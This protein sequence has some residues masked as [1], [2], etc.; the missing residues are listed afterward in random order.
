MSLSYR[1]GRGGLALAGLACGPTLLAVSAPVLGA[2]YFVQPV[3]TVTAEQN[4]NIDLDPFNPSRVAGYGADAAALIGVATPDSETT[5]KPR[6]RYADYPKEST[7][8]RVEGMVDFSTRLSAPRSLF[9][10]SGRFDHLNDTE[11]EAPS[12]QF[13]EVNPNAPTTSDAGR[14]QFG[15]TRNYV[16]LQPRYQYQVAPLVTLGASALFQNESFSVSNP[17]DTIGHVNFNYYLGDFFVSRKFGEKTELLIG[18]FASRYAADNVSP[19]KSNASASGANV[20]LEY[21]WS[22]ALEVD[23]AASFQHST[24]DSTLTPAFVGTSHNWGASG[25][26]TYSG[27]ANTFRLDIGRS[28]TPGSVGSLYSDDHLHI[29]LDRQISERLSYVLAARAVATRGLWSNVGSDD[30]NYVRGDTS[31]KWMINRTLIVQGGYSYFWQRYRTDPFSA[32]NNQFY[33]R[34]GYQGLP[35]QR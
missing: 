21:H 20:G 27:E 1:K 3:A 34:F 35:P 14:V 5:I 10:V 13:N 24:I 25:G 7:L 2:E 22:K 12:A 15:V 17:A 23:L 8:N 30:R 26:L 6:I 33:I 4:S 32:E 9:T 18:G 16:I 29:E 28:I 19:L 11:A 31:V